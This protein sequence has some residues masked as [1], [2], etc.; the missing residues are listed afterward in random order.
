M[1]ITGPCFG[2]GVQWSLVTYLMPLPSCDIAHSR[3]TC[4]KPRTSTECHLIELHGQ[5][6][7]CPRLFLE[8]FHSQWTRPKSACTARLLPKLL[9]LQIREQI[10]IR[11]SWEQQELKW[12]YCWQWAKFHVSALGLHSSTGVEIGLVAPAKQSLSHY[13]VS[14][15]IWL[16][17]VGFGSTPRKNMTKL[18]NVT[19]KRC[20]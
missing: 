7:L 20:S 15:R 2:K 6:Y 18:D 14:G 8:V 11:E 13:K 12:C 4:P 19:T 16:T 9:W 1:T 5:I 17:S 3:G 10:F